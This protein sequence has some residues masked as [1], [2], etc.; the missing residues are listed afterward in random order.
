MT[1]D[2]L[3]IYIDGRSAEPPLHPITHKHREL[4]GLSRCR[5]C[6]CD[7]VRVHVVRRALTG[8]NQIRRSVTDGS[9]IGFVY[10]QSCI[11]FPTLCVCVESL[12]LCNLIKIIIM[13]WWTGRHHYHC[14]RMTTRN[15]VR[16]CVQQMYNAQI[17]FVC[18][19]NCIIIV[20]AYCLCVICDYKDVDSDS[21]HNE[22]NL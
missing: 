4:P 17:V 12:T 19:Y 18:V 21:K 14:S 2:Q 20:I 3:Q 1:L 15:S 10:V 22:D 11:T 5:Q 16:R 7:S 6:R 9:T 13:I 8:Q